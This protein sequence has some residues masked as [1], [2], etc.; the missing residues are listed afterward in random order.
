MGA[1]MLGKFSRRKFLRG[2]LV[3]PAVAPVILRQKEEL[4]SQ[5]LYDDRQDET[6]IPP[7]DFA[8]AK[9]ITHVLL[10]HYPGHPW[11]VWV[12][13]EQGVGLIRNLGLKI[14]GVRYASD[15]AM[16]MHLK[17][18]VNDPT[19]RTVVKMGGEM[20]E[21]WNIDRDKYRKEDYVDNR[22]AFND[23]KIAGP[24]PRQ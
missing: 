21:R 23:V 7:A 18:L 24:V 1:E 10:Q 5:I 9:Q 4:P 13:H 15:Y 17:D 11:A 14:S 19:L 6:G 3:A 8:L 16:N 2:A 20:L 22:P 12:S